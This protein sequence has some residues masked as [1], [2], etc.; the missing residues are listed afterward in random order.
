MLLALYP[1]TLYLPSDP[2]FF[3]SIKNPYILRCED[4]LLVDGNDRGLSKSIFKSCAARDRFG[5]EMPCCD[6]SWL[7]ATP[8]NPLNVGQYVNNEDGGVH[9]HNVIYQEVRLPLPTSAQQGFPLQ[10]WRFLPNVWYN[11]SNNA[12]GLRLVPLV[13]IRDIEE[14]E[15]LFSSYFTI[16]HK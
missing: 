4:G 15:E 5:W 11:P 14:G 2:L 16:V 12:V 9:K 3:A 7:T 13:A 1:G 10:F 6:K 8:V